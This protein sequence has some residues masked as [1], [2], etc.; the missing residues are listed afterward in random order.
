MRFILSNFLSGVFLSLCVILWNNSE[1]ISQVP[2]PKDVYG[3]TPGDDYKL[4]G[5]TI[6]YKAPELRPAIQAYYS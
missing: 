1:L 5:G 3:F 4:F 2:H 6:H